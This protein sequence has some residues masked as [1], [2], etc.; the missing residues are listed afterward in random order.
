MNPIIIGLIVATA[1]SGT[2]YII[3]KYIHS[4][5]MMVITK[6]LAIMAIIAIGVINLANHYSIE[7][8]LVVLGLM[9]GMLGDICLLRREYFK[10]GLVAF[11]IGHALLIPAFLL[12]ITAVDYLALVTFTLLV[13]LAAVQLLRVLLPSAGKLRIPVICYFTVIILMAIAAVALFSGQPDV[14]SAQLIL[15]GALLFLVSDAVLG[16]DRIVAPLAIGPAVISLTYYPAQL[17]FALAV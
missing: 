14:A 6:P 16:Y 7:G 13:S 11:L 4:R 8:V 3:A 17:A 12:Q 9:F 15:I 10:A 2:L 5:P 1:I